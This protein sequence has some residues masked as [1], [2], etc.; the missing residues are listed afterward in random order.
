MSWLLRSHGRRLWLLVENTAGAGGTIGR[1][2]DELAAIFDRLDRHPR[3]G[4]C[5][6]SRHL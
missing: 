3:L 4:L 1:S 5:L 2:T 6:D